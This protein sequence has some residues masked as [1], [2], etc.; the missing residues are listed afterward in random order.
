MNT[1]AQA[2]H[3]APTTIERLFNSNNSVNFWG[4]LLTSGFAGAGA[5]YE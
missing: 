4:S 5:N 3:F 2:N 1:I